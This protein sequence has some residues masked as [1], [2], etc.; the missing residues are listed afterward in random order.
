MKSQQAFTG[1]PMR[2]I[3][4][5]VSIQRGRKRLKQGWARVSKA[6]R[7][8]LTASALTDRADAAAYDKFQC[9]AL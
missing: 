3:S 2:H 4:L 8:A 1:R 6:A 5:K 7:P 9:R